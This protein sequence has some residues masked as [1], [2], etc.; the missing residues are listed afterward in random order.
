MRCF[1]EEMEK[2]PI[3]GIGKMKVSF[4]TNCYEADWEALLCTGRL[5]EMIDRCNYQFSFRGL[6]INNVSKP[7]LVKAW[8]E[9]AIEEKVIDA[10]Y[11]SADYSDLVLDS[12]KITRRSFRLDFFDGY[13]YSMGPLTALYVCPTPWLLYF[14]CDCMINRDATSNWIDEAML[15]MQSDPCVACATP[16]WDYKPKD[17]VFPAYDQNQ[18]WVIAPGFSD[19][20]F[21]VSTARFRQPI[22]GYYHPSCDGFPVYAGNLFERRVNGFLHT[23]S[24]V[25]IVH[26]TISYSHEKLGKS[27]ENGKRIFYP[28]LKKLLAKWSRKC[29]RRWRTGLYTLSHQREYSQKI[30]MLL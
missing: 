9:K 19:Q 21:L 28:A 27:D 7:D 16:M 22:Y 25:R 23:K 1:S 29:S 17:L 6:I 8:A 20:V 3:V 18:E 30:G 4:F 15:I 2:Q 26:L 10:Y 13:W 11:F 12:F 24:L 5:A 14:T